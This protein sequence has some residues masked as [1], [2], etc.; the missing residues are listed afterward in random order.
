MGCAEGRSPGACPESD[1]GPGV[2]EPAL[3]PSKGCPSDMISSPFLARACPDLEEGK[4][5]RGWSPMA[6]GSAPLMLE[7]PIFVG[8]TQMRVLSEA[9][10]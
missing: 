2:R 8:M 6:V 7:N 5:A 4:G 9:L 1:E 10:S 3:S